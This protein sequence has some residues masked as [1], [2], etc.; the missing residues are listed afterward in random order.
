V[1]WNEIAHAPHQAVADQVTAALNEIG[2]AVQT[3]P[4]DLLVTP[5][6][7]R[8]K[9]GRGLRVF[10]PFWKR[11]RSFGGPPKPLPAPKALY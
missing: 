10:T 11:V 1:F 5:T 8:S 2:V 4:G 7:I 6:D 9:D 3:F